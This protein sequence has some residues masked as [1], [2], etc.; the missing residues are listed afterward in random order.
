MRKK[1][2]TAFGPFFG[3]TLCKEKKVEE[4]VN[5]SLKNKK[6]VRQSP[7]RRE[8]PLYGTFPTASKFPFFGW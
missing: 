7:V 2:I 1:N 8:V 6:S 3:I 5:P 4:F